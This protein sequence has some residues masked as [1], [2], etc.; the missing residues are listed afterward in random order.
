MFL[1]KVKGES[2]WHPWYNKIEDIFLSYI[3]L[4]MTRMYGRKIGHDDI[5]VHYVSNEQESALC[6]MHNEKSDRTYFKVKSGKVKLWNHTPEIPAQYQVGDV[7]PNDNTKTLK[8]SDPRT[9]PTSRKDVK[10]AQDW[11]VRK[12]MDWEKNPD[13]ARVTKGKHRGLI[14][15]TRLK[16]NILE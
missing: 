5:E 11:N 10:N 12:V 16:K 14:D 4:Q 7:D 8:A 3:P 6:K 2:K 13:R 15:I 1:I 9:H